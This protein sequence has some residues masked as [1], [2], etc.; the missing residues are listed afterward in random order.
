MF[1]VPWA[2]P[3]RVSHCLGG[4]EPGLVCHIRTFLIVLLCFV[5]SLL[6][7]RCSELIADYWPVHFWILTDSHLLRPRLRLTCLPASHVA[8]SIHPSRLN[9]RSSATSPPPHALVIGYTSRPTKT[10]LKRGSQVNL[11]LPVGTHTHPL[12]NTCGC[13]IL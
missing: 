1:Q 6:L 4:G 3:S 9:Q 10:W 12:K 7:L 8:G 2:G 5:C 11:S 13:W